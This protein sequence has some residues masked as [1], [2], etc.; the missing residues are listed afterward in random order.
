MA[1]IERAFSA[2]KLVKTNLPNRIGDD[3]CMYHCLITYVEMMYAS[4]LVPMLLCIHIKLVC[5]IARGCYHKFISAIYKGINLLGYNWSQPL[6]CVNPT[7]NIAP[8]LSTSTSPSTLTSRINISVNHIINQRTD[9]SISQKAQHT[10][11]L[12]FHHVSDSSIHSPST[13]L[14]CS[15]AGSVEAVPILY[16]GVVRYDLSPLERKEI[17]FASLSSLTAV[18]AP[19]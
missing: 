16:L 10:W 17:V 12:R 5:M 11:C 15:M 18:L 19:R 6:T 9:P 13:Y 14:R 2:M 4:Q 3:Y 1:T 7:A 8:M